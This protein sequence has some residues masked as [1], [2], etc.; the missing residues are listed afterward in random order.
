MKRSSPSL[1]NSVNASSHREI[2]ESLPLPVYDAVLGNLEDILR[3]VSRIT[4]ESDVYSRK[5][6]ASCLDISSGQRDSD[7]IFYSRLRSIIK[8]ERP[9]IL[10]A[11]EKDAIEDDVMNF[12]FS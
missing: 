11:D 5:L 4:K 10:D 6:V 9:D 8:D 12:M 1:S 3:H 2:V 7:S